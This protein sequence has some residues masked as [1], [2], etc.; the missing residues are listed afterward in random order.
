MN[1]SNSSKEYILKLSKDQNVEFVS[2]WFTDILGFLKSF[3]ITIDELDDVLESG[4]SFDGSSIEG[5]ARIDESDMFCLPDLSTFQVLP[6]EPRP[7]IG[8]ARIFCDIVTPNG[9]PYPGDPRYVLKRSLKKASDLG[10]E[11]NVGPELEFFYFKDSE[12]PPKLLDRAGYFDQVPSDVGRILRKETVMALR[13]LGIQVETSHHECAHSQQEIDLKYGEALVMADNVM[14]YRFVVKEVAVQSGHYATFMPKPIPGINGSG[15]HVNMSLFTDGE[16]AFH[17]DNEEDNLSETGRYFLSGLLR[18]AREISAITNQ[19][20][21][22]YKRLTPGY[23]A[24]VY[25]T[26]ARRNRSDLIRVPSCKR[27]RTVNTRIEYRSPDPA[28]NPYLAFA[29]LLC[30]GLEGIEKKYELPSPFNGNVYSLSDTERNKMGIQSLPVD[31]HEA[32]TELEQSDLVKEVLGEHLFSK[33]LE[34]K[35]IEWDDYCVQVTNF[36]LERYFPSL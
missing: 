27:G 2:L 13:S 10:Y 6:W 14:T 25:I 24:P 9:D 7:N 30:A 21:N 18:H 20:V 32:V 26:W 34:N 1:R 17:E 36:E 3:T 11:Y 29:V 33:F 16:N 23:E 5:F 22:S 31:L 35:R 8:V 19:Y 15:M 4:A 28:C 12:L